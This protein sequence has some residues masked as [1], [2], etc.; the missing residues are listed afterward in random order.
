MSIYSIQPGQIPDEVDSVEIDIEVT[1]SNKSEMINLSFDID[2]TWK[3]PELNVDPNGFNVYPNVDEL[4]HIIGTEENIKVI[5]KNS[6]GVGICNV[7]VY[8][9]LENNNQNI[10]YGEINQLVSESCESN[11]SNNDEDNSSVARSIEDKIK[12]K[13]YESLRDKPE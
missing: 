10:S 12:N 7:P 13:R 4:I 2:P 1:V 9:R 8:F 11:Q 3:Y 5:S 6:N